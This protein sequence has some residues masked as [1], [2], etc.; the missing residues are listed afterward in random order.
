M[1]QSF[2]IEEI[3][4]T[5]IFIVGYLFYLLR[6]IRINRVL[7]VS[8]NRIVTKA[9]L[10]TLAFALLLT[11]LLGPLFGNTS[12]EIQA[13]GK[14]ILIVLDLSQSMN[15][16]DVQPSRLEKVKY[17]LKE[18]IDTFAGDKIGLIIF[19]SEAFV[20]CPLTYDQGALTLFTST[21]HTGLVPNAGTNFA[22]SL[23]MAIDK[24]DSEEEKENSN[25]Q[26]AKLILLISDGEDFSTRT[27]EVI[28]RIKQ[29][30]I[31]VFT[32]G[33]GTEKGSNILVRGRPKIDND[34][35]EVTTKLSSSSLKNIASKTGGKYFEISDRQNDMARLINTISRV[36]GKLQDTRQIDVSANKYEYFLAA[37]LLLIVIDQ[38]IRFRVVKL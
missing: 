6:M 5:G 32:L 15:A 29:D 24:L 3:V 36:E 18:L 14:D 8:F 23:E 30:N 13:V 21:L 1:Y 9:V 31:N 2:G 34:G 25:Q 16:R 33:V 19:S 10:R 22:N 26:S 35:N 12:R 38:I 27:E 4:F 11:A 20:Q 28:E 7:K 17:E 37:A